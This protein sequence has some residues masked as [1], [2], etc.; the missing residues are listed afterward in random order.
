ML[1][2]LILKPNQKSTLQQIFDFPNKN[3]I[4]FLVQSSDCVVI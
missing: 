1:F 3:E 4:E 2:Y